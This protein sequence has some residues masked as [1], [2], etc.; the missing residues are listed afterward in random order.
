MFD[1]LTENMLLELDEH[2]LPNLNGCPESVVWHGADV[3]CALHSCKQDVVLELGQNS[4]ILQRERWRTVYLGIES[5][6]TVLDWLSI[7][8]PARF[9]NLQ[10]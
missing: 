10:W 5:M 6:V 8:V 2:L 9:K 3:L 7:G 4:D 1:A